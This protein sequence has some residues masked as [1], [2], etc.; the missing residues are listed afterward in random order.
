VHGDW[1]AAEVLATELRVVKEL[2]DGFLSTQTIELD[3]FSLD[4][5]FTRT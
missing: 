4:A 5:A 1:I 3:G 2:G